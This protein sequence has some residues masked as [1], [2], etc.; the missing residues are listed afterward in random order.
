MCC[1]TIFS[2]KNPIGFAAEK[3]G[4]KT[5]PQDLDHRAETILQLAQ[6]AQRARAEPKVPQV[7][8]RLLVEE[9]LHHLGGVKPYEWWEK[10]PTSTGFHAGFVP[11][12]GVRKR[13]E[14]GIFDSCNFLVP[15]HSKRISKKKHRYDDPIPSV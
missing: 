8:W 13:F 11:S 3:C 12:T 10:L 7:W 9:T 2:K 5:Q 15:V 14:G 1:F 4:S 6:R